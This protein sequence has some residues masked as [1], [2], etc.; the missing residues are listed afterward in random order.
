MIREMFRNF[1]N[2]FFHC[3]FSSDYRFAAPSQL[4]AKTPR[5]LEYF[6]WHFREESLVARFFLKK[7][8]ATS[9]SPARRPRQKS[10]S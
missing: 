7:N 3:F 2:I 1:E 4:A 5:E 6:S 8:P 10:P 9:T